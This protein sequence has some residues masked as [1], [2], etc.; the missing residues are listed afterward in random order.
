MRVWV[1]IT[2]PHA[3]D[4]NSAPIG[5][6]KGPKS[7]PKGPQERLKKTIVF[8][9]HDLNEAF[10]LGSRVAIMDAG[11][12]VQQGRAEDILRQP[13][14]DYVADFI[15]H[16]NPLSVMKA[17]WVMKPIGPLHDGGQE[18]DVES[19]I[20]VPPESSIREEIKTRHQNGGPILVTE[21]RNVLGIIDDDAIYE[22]IM[23]FGASEAT[24]NS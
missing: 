21:G 10:R 17:R 6:T 18:F 8:V 13:A 3:R 19:S 24:P 11:Q 23:T 9:S 4:P 1:Y 14:N 12:V 2:V 15:A 5:S 7:A 16:L 20:T 22:A